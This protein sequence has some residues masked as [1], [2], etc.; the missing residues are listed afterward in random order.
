MVAIDCRLSTSLKFISSTLI[1]ATLSVHDF[2]S[3]A[4]KPLG[5]SLLGL[6]FLG[7]MNHV[8]TSQTFHFT[9]FSLYIV[10]RKLMSS[11]TLLA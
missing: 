9:V 10:E 11:R 2:L 3:D 7:F 5:R 8:S 4:F 1:S 6:D